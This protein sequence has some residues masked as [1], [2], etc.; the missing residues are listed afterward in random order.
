MT[1]HRIFLI[2][3][4][5]FAASSFSFAQNSKLKILEKPLPE[6]PQNYETLDIQ[7]TIVLHIQFLDF[8][9]IGE[10][11]AVKE[12]SGL[13]ERAVA[14]AKKIRFEPERIDGKP[15]T[16]SRNI[17]Y[18]YSWNGGW[19]FPSEDGELKPADPA[20]AGKAD[21]IVAKAIKLVGGDRYLKAATQVSRGKFSNIK[22][23][24]V[25]SF[26]SF[27]DAIA[28]P[29]RERTEFK[30]DGSRMTQVN[31]GETGWIFDGDQELIKVQTPLQIENFKRGQRTSLDN[32]LRGYWKGM[33]DLRFIGTRPSSLGRRNNV[34]S[35]TYK[36]GFTVEFEFA[37]NDGTPQKATYKQEREGEETVTEED[38]YA[39]FVEVDGIKVPFIIDRFTSGK[40]S[41][42]INYESVEFNVKLPEAVFAK[43]ASVKEA[44]KDLKY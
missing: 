33:A 35:L 1:L 36:D 38:R 40:Q 29:D 6:R 5:V 30:G 12:L 27:V 3:L 21:G 4:V 8:G 10:V 31:T 37:A 34:V 20:D 26:Q 2:F 23:G 11:T 18:Y 19:R 43:P 13:T 14:A 28:F 32:L 9:E 16:V 7:G 24:A 15:V 41:S 17:E 44:K 25:V 22:E 42:R 39:Q